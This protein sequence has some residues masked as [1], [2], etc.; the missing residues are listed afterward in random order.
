MNF[1]VEILSV[2]G[3]LL[4]SVFVLQIFYSNNNSLG[5][6]S[7]YSALMILGTYLILEGF[8]ISI[9]QPNLSRIVRHVQNGT[10]DFI[11]LKPLDTQF[12]LSTRRITPWGIPSVLLG[13]ALII[14][15]F[16]KNRVILDL[17]NIFFSLVIFLS[18]LI[19][20]Y[21]LWFI[22]ASTSIWFVKVWNASEVLR[23]VLVASRYPVYAFPPILRSIFTFVLPLA[24]LTTIPVEVLLGRSSWFYIFLSIGFSTLFFTISRFFWKFAMR[25][26]TSAS[27]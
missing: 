18:S 6:W 27:S 16:I 26:Y 12:W 15:S 2:I 17:V 1:F 7:W 20:L 14:Y 19:I 24:F 23:S 3:N 4:G 11:L 22:L 5:G 8:T 10:L 21:S 9:L 13:F 25:Y